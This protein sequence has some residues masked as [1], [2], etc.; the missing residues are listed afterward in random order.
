[1][2]QATRRIDVRRFTGLT[3]LLVCTCLALVAGIGRAAQQSV[4]GP[5]HDYI[6][7]VVSEAA[8]RITRLRFGPSG[9]KIERELT[10]GIMPT[11]PDG[12]HGLVVSPDR[13]FYYLSLGHGQPAGWALKYAVRDDR[14]VGQV[15]L[16]LFPASMDVTRDAR[17]RDDAGRPLCVRVG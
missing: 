8:D 3:R 6:V 15:A 9:G 1:M 11:S 17:R 7:Y 13:E 5:A 14:V 10:T 12:P 16:G 4:S 2:R